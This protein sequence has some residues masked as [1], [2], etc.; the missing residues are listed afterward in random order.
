MK[1]DT[2]QLA[3]YAVIIII[4]G[5]S[6][7]IKKVL[8]ARSKRRL[9]EAQQQKQHKSITAEDSGG[10][11]SGD[12]SVEPSR[13][14]ETPYEEAKPVPVPRPMVE[15]EESRERDSDK[16]GPE[17]VD[18]EKMLRRALGFPSAADVE[19]KERER[20]DAELRQQQVQVK[21][22]GIQEE[23]KPL[24]EPEEM[25]GPETVSIMDIEAYHKSNNLDEASSGWTDFLDDLNERQPSELARAIIL[26]E[27][28]APPIVLRRHKILRSRLV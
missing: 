4:I 24:E 18:L 6:S 14:K 16:S 8:E 13:Q 10:L 9:E 5:L 25:A 19:R 1:D 20:K 3:A 21:P 26:S 7:V 15:T 12:N 11:R 27:L 2:V 17:A 28:V 22:V 23:V